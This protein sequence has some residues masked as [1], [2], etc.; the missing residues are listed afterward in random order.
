L[1]ENDGDVTWLDRKMTNADAIL[2]IAELEE[3]LKFILTVLNWGSLDGIEF[4]AYWRAK[5]LVGT[6]SEKEWAIRKLAS[7][8]RLPPP[9]FPHKSLGSSPPEGEVKKGSEVD[10]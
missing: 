3:E 9:L 7:V 6:P 8:W 4:M 1:D 2:R 5:A 10:S